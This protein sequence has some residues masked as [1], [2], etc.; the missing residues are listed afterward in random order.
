MELNSFAEK[1]AEEAVKL[2]AFQGI[3]LPLIKDKLAVILAKIGANGIF[4]EYTKHDV[5]HVN[6]VLSLLD[7]IIP[8][9]TKEIM[10]GADWLMI[11]LAVYFHDMGMFVSK[12]EYEARNTNSEYV[13][14]K[15]SLLSKVDLKD[16]LLAMTSDNRERFMYQEFVRH[17][18]GR[19][20][21]SWIE[22]TGDIVSKGFQTEL[23]E[24]LKGFDN[25][26]K[27]SLA[28]ICESHQVDD[29]DIDALDVNKAFGSSD[30]ETSN[31]LYVSLLLRTADL[32]HITHDRTPSTEYNVI[33]VKDP[34]SQTEWV[35]QHSVKQ[36]NIYYDKDEEGSIDKTKQPSKF[37]VQASFY[38]PVAFFSFDS[39]LNY[40][41]KEIEKNHHIYDKVK[42]RTTKA[43]NYPWIGINRDKIVGKG[44]ETR[45]L[46]FEIDKKKILDLLMGHTLYN[47]TTVVLRELVQNGIDACR[48][49]NSTL[50][51]TAHY[52]PKIKISYDKAKHELKVQ[53]NGTGMSRDTIFKHLLRVGCSRYQDPDFI[54]EHPTFHSISHF[55]IGLLTCFMVCDDVDIYTKEAGGVARLLQ[56]K[57]LHGNFIMRDEKT[58]SEILE[59][60]HGSTFILRLRPSID[61]KD[62]KTIVKKWIVL[63]SMQVTY[64]VD[65]NEEKVGFDSAKEYIYAQLAS[66][67]IMESDAN[68]KVD[69]VKENGI[70]VTSLLKKDPLTKVWRLCDNHD[71]DISRDAPLV[72]T[73]IEGVRVTSYTP[74]FKNFAYVSI[75]NCL[76][77]NAPYTN[78]ARTNIER[79]VKYDNMLRAVYRSFLK[80]VD[81]Q[82]RDLAASYSLTWASA[83]ISYVLNKMAEDNFGR[84]CILSQEIFDECVKEISFLTIED[85]TARK[86]L[87]LKDFPNKVWTIENRAY[88]A[89]TDIMREVKDSSHTAMKIL[90]ECTENFCADDAVECVFP[91][92]Y[93][94]SYVDNLFYS[95]FEISSLNGDRIHRKLCI[96]RKRKEKVGKSNWM[97]INVSRR[98]SRR[99][100]ENKIFIPLSKDSFDYSKNKDDFAIL[101]S[102]V[103]ILIPETPF[104]EVVKRIFESFDKLNNRRADDLSYFIIHYIHVLSKKKNEDV[105]RYIDS[106][107][108][109]TES[110]WNGLPITK[111]EFLDAIPV[112]PISVFSNDVYYT[113]EEDLY[114]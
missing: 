14:F 70:E 99:V 39:Y 1:K 34:F 74:G 22:N 85:Q 60:K 62:F 13:D 100:A 88:N 59:G 35:K 96:C 41:E 50:K 55:G 28:L 27:E 7:K 114:F 65:G 108:E 23:S 63:P 67:G 112:N 79:G 77:E 26:L 64:S 49:F 107:D 18:H 45:K 68:Y 87:S 11:T 71:F 36:V 104:Y 58:D 17:N 98:A 91:N 93:T 69:V 57:D 54:N 61:T 109:F 111:Q 16:K 72:G 46:Y 38:D 32:L 8:S 6:G 42:G 75:A 5:S 106:Q 48:M 20:V 83:E 3:N 89:A 24:M 105:R 31:L 66:Q 52:E 37:E 97:I 78:V 21:K 30:E 12:E 110:F 43:Y 80:I 25:E 2:F 19:R 40:A 44:F 33:D 86:L 53:D 29:L 51:S 56:I 73:C 9:Q 10:T 47:D 95:D 76:G 92:Q 4:D 82:T 84:N 113:H 81:D 90:G 94:T 103:C 101:S 102:K 15:T